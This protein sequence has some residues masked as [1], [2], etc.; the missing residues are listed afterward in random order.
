MKKLECITKKLKC[1]AWRTENFFIYNN[2]TITNM[3]KIIGEGIYQNYQKTILEKEGETLIPYS[4]KEL[5][6]N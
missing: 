5:G 3:G 1:L 2:I 4:R 6:L